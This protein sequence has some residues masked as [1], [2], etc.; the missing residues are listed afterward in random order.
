MRWHKHFDSPSDFAA[1]TQSLVQELRARQLGAA[2]DRL[3]RVT[4]CAYS[5]RSEWLGDLGLALRDLYA[6]AI[7]DDL[8]KKLDLVRDE[9]RIA[10]P[11]FE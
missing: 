10:W 5:S 11:G 4:S 2:A 9:V 7:P 3:E 8:R 1:F 6:M